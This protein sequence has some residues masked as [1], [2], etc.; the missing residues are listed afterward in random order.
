MS[1]WDDCITASDRGTVLSRNGWSGIASHCI[2][3][4]RPMLPWLALTYTAARLG[5]EAQNAAAFRLLRL[6]GGIAKTA[7]DEIVPEAIMPRADTAPAPVVAAPKTRHAAR[8][9]HKKSAP[10]RKRGKRAKRV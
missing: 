6:G 5:F 2:N 8:K 1:F 7:A 9:I 10:V 4:E 3:G